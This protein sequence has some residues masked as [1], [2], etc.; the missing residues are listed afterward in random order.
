M[1]VGSP[2]HCSSAKPSFCD[3]TLDP[4]IGLAILLVSPPSGT[5]P[6]DR[7]V[8]SLDRE[9]LAQDQVA[10]AEDWI[11]G[12]FDKETG[13]SRWRGS[14]SIVLHGNPVPSNFMEGT[15]FTWTYSRRRVLVSETSKA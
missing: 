11:Q 3:L 15:P 12:V 7:E 9:R 13:G 5:K 1:G 14:P 6:H 4:A 2:K 8:A 10:R